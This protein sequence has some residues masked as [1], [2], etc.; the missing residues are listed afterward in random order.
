MSFLET[1]H[2]LDGGRTNRGTA[3]LAMDCISLVATDYE[4]I[5]TAIISR[6]TV[7]PILQRS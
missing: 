3:I 7:T 4:H 6:N 1:H 2:P 5:K